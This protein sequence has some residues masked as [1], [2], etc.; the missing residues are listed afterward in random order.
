MGNCFPITPPDPLFYK[1][2]KYNQTKKIIYRS[3]ENGHLVTKFIY[4]DLKFLEVKDTP[5]R[6]FLVDEG[7]KEFT[8]KNNNIKVLRNP[9]KIFKPFEDLL[10]DFDDPNDLDDLNDLDDRND[11]DEDE[12]PKLIL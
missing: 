7:L 1:G 6:Y 8:F 5:K 4:D 10:N 11:L 2:K 12:F 9:E 3:K